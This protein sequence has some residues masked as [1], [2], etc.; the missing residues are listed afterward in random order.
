[1][2][3]CWD[4]ENEN[5]Q[6]SLVIVRLY[7]M[8]TIHIWDKTEKLSV[9]VLLLVHVIVFVSQSVSQ[10]SM[11]VSQACQS[12]KQSVKPVKITEANKLNR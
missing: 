1:M 11:S 8:L 3:S 12:D 4:H 9:S 7:M 2:V 6:I 10:S 5:K